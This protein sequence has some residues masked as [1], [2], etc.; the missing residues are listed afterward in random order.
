MGADWYSPLT[1]YGFQIEIPEIYTYR[2]Y[3]KIIIEIESIIPNPFEFM[4][5]LSEFPDELS[6]FPDKLSKLDNDAQLIIGFRPDNN[7]T[8]ML[9]LYNELSEYITDSPVLDGITFSSEAKFFTGIDWYSHFEFNDDDS[10][11]EEESEEES[12]EETEEESEEESDEESEEDS[13]TDEEETEEESEE[14][15]E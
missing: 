13:E 12:D 5:I 1:F 10:D 15:S 9:E 7:L 8:K 2:E 11:S 14:N 3:C 6:E 4:G